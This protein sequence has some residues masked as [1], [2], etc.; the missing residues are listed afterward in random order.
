VILDIGLPSLDGMEVLKQIRQ[1]NPQM[2][3]IMISASGVK[4]SAVRAIGL[5]A[6]AYLLKPFDIQELQRVL[7]R[8]FRTT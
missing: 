1:K 5:G 7:E 3:T 8:C 4:E 2:P 6:Q